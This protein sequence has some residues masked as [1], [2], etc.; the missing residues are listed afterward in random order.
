MSDWPQD[1]Q[2]CLTCTGPKSDY[3]YG[4]RNMC[5]RCYR[6]TR[7]IEAAVAFPDDSNSQSDMS[8][9]NVDFIDQEKIEIYRREVIEQ[10]KRKLNQL[11]LYE[12]HRRMEIPVSGLDVEEK[13]AEL[14]RLVGNKRGHHQIANH[15]SDKF[16]D[17][18]RR[19]LYALLSEVAEE[20][21]RRR[22]TWGMLNYRVIQDR[23]YNVTDALL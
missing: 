4:G 17:T 5:G 23:M 11:M 13:F 16:N 10:L 7:R 1:Q 18:Q 14:M 15:I 6:L 22:K 9:L 3:A 20:S 2:A 8:F 12:Q 21:K 19:V